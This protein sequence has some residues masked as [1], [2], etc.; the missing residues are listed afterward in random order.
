MRWVDGLAC[1]ALAAG[2]STDPPDAE[3]SPPSAQT[4]PTRLLYGR[5]HDIADLNVGIPAARVGAGSASTTTD[6][7][8]SFRLDAP[9]A[10]DRLVVDASDAGWAPQVVHLPAWEGSLEVWPGMLPNDEAERAAQIMAASAPELSPVFRDD[11][12]YLI[13]QARLANRREED[14]EPA[15]VTIDV[16]GASAD[17]VFVFRYND[18]L[19][20]CLPV[21][22]PTAAIAT[23]A[24]C[25]HL[26]VV[27]EI[28]AGAT[29]DLRFVHPTR[30]CAR[31]PEER[32]A[33]LLSGDVAFSIQVDPGALNVTGVDC[34]HD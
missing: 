14:L 22:E 28:P 11:V 29:V 24:A 23:S 3:V 21:R 30:L 32:E 26:L 8:G 33:G 31:S 25:G 13:A 10:A 12:A 4:G 27:P 15:E 18:L 5:V 16:D 34:E 9:A 7:T 17:P 20:E 6:A 1:C 2:C 19:G